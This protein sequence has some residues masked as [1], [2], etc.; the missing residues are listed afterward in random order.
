MNLADNQ[1]TNEYEQ[2]VLQLP[3]ATQGIA[4]LSSQG[5]LVVNGL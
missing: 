1:K 5:I 4:A 3:G 2:E